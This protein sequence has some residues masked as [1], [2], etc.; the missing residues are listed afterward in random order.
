MGDKTTSVMLCYVQ[1]Q[2]TKEQ[3]KAHHYRLSDNTFVQPFWSAKQTHLQERSLVSQK[4]DTDLEI[5][6]VPLQTPE[7]KGGILCS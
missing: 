1:P 3:M 5:P 4:K 6:M 7:G 2:G